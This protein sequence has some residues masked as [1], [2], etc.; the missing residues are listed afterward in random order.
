MVPHFEKMLYDNALLLRVYAHLHRVTGSA[1]ALRVA[2]ET[3]GF[4]L[5]DL[6][7]AEGGFAS[8]LDAD[9]EGVEGKTYAWTPAQLRD[10]LGAED[11]AWAAELLT[12]T[13]GGTF[14]HG[15]STLQLAVDPAD[16]ARWAR[17]KAALLAAR[18][19][20]PQPA[21]DDKVVTAW[22][23]L[24]IVAL[25]EGGAA[26]DRPEWVDRRR[27]GRRPAAGPPRRRRTPP[28]LLARRRG[29]RGGGRAGGPRRAGRRPARAAPG[30]RCAPVARGRDGAARRGPRALRRR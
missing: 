11:G 7:T 9:T 16:P 24:A 27:A 20:R 17:V 28:P 3:A 15:A 4:L 5:R 21:R 26:L 30:H 13:D 2:D 10:V 12:V 23:G 25:A 14:E 19:E 6:I 29:R 22:N 8:A 1:L 18:A